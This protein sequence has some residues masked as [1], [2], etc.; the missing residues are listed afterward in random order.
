MDTIFTLE[1]AEWAHHKKQPVA[2]MLLGYESAFA[3]LDWSFLDNWFVY[4]WIGALSL[5]CRV[6]V[7]FLHGAIGCHLTSY[8][9]ILFAAAIALFLKARAMGVC[10]L[11]LPFGVN[12]KLF[13]VEN[14]DDTSLYL[15]KSE[16]TFE[17]V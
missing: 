14:A 10:G 2:V 13:D 3:R 12:E 6:V 8:V 17:T 4:E 7:A 16:E 15:E 11:R 1:A 5:L 9:F